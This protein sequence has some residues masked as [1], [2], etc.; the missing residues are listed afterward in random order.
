MHIITARALRSPAIQG[1][2]A[3]LLLAGQALCASATDT[4]VEFYNTTLIHYFLTIDPTEAVAIDSGSAGP[5]WQR[6]GKTIAA[7]RSA[8]GATVGAVVVCRFYGNQSNGGANGHFYTA[9]A[10]E[11]TSVKLDPGWM[12]ERNEFYAQAATNGSCPSGSLPVY[13]AYNGRFAQHDS[14]HRYTT[15]ARDVQPEAGARLARR[16]RCVLRGFVD[17]VEPRRDEAA[18]G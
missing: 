7:Y 9:D 1:I 18:V 13:R 17:Y 8:S 10:A 3:S 4:L 12:F 6:T 5:G 14:N 16:R 2:L 15:D 11:C